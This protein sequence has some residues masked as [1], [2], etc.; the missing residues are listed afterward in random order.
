MLGFSFTRIPRIGTACACIGIALGI[1]VWASARVLVTDITTPQ[2]FE[3]SIV[4][5]TKA[6]QII[7]TRKIERD[8]NYVLRVTLKNVSAKNIVS[9]TY[10]AGQAGITNSFALSENLFAAGET[11]EEDVPY[12]SLAVT[13]LSGHEGDLVF[14]GVL[15]E[16]GTGDGEPKFV[17]QMS[18][19][20]AGL[21]E[22]AGRIVPLLRRA[23]QDLG[24][25]DNDRTLSDLELEI[26]QL[27]VEEKTFSQSL[28]NKLG[29]STANRQFASRVKK[30]RENTNNTFG[31]NRKTEIT[32]NL[33]AWEHILTRF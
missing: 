2:G 23:Q 6:L 21:R 20:Y 12:E 10:L 13:A 26:S 27:P 5:K 25:T 9:Y 31:P 30:L 1:A 11:S 19:E 18:D 4:N 8:Q 22:Q 28:D 33:A 29:R 32:G 17:K 7:S 14:E 15:F 24:D 3:P 16:G